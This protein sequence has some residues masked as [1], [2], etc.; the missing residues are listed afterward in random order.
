MRPARARRIRRLTAV[1]LIA[2]GAI[3]CTG[4]TIGTQTYRDATFRWTISYAAALQ[5]ET[6]TTDQGRFGLEGILLT[7]FTPTHAGDG[8][9]PSMDWLRS[10]PDDGVALQ[11]WHLEGPADEPPLADD[12]PPA[13]LGALAPTDRYVGGSEP[14]PRYT[15]FHANGTSFNVAVWLGAG[16]SDADRRAMASA[17][18]SMRFAPLQP[19]TMWRDWY[20]VLDDAE[21]YPVGSVTPIPATR[22]DVPVGFTRSE[23]V[24]LVHAPGGFYAIPQVARLQDLPACRVLFDPDTFRFSCPA[25]GLTWDRNGVA[26]D[27]PPEASLDPD[28]G[29]HPVGVTLHGQ[30]IYCPF[31]GAIEPKDL[32]S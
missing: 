3:A 29:P 18:A 12:V 17:L 25:I 6:L 21:D 26:I 22:L 28:I 19:W 32:W 8:G 30:V 7:N 1:S 31:F 15:W 5:L 27:P 13:T 4:P 23:S 10:F 2:F 20:Y 11:L 16:A 24:Y 14:R 9:T